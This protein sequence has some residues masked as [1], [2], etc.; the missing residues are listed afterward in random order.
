MQRAFRKLGA[1][2]ERQK[3]KIEEAKVG[4]RQFRRFLHPFDS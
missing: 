2:R 4:S 1:R 3:L